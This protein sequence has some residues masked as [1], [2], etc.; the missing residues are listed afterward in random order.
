MVECANNIFF[1]L[2]DAN[3]TITAVQGATISINDMSQT[4]GMQAR[5]SLPSQ[6]R[7]P[8]RVAAR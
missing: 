3:F 4:E 6:S 1:D 5:A 2:S 7:C 8:R